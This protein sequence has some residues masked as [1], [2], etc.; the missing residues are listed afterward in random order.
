MNQ[1]K[2]DPYDKKTFKKKHWNSENILYLVGR[3][4]GGVSQIY[5][6]KNVSVG[7]F[8]TFRHPLATVC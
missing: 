4:R 6:K 5:E 1:E 3:G 8:S 7:L 2:I